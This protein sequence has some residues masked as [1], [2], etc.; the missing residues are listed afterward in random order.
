[1]AATLTLQAP[2]SRADC[3]DRLEARIDRRPVSF[4]IDAARPVRGRSS[5]EGF[6]VRRSRDAIVDARGV[7]LPAGDGTR[8]DLRF[9]TAWR[10]QLW[11]MAANA[12][13]LGSL[14]GVV[15]AGFGRI[16]GDPATVI[17]T[18]SALLAAVIVVLEVVLVF[19]AVLAYGPRQRAFLRTF[20]EQTLAAR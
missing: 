9:T 2:L 1:M 14:G 18:A 12:L 11:W 20:L 3:H 16:P 4:L 13:I 7:Y 17:A 5:L 8:I 19:V 6:V 15:L 10:S